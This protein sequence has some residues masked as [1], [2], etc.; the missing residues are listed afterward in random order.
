[1]SSNVR[2][3]VT[4]Q[5]ERAAA[6]VYRAVDGLNEEQA[7]RAEI[8]GWSVKDHI[9]HLAFWHELR[10][11]E[12]G[13][14]ARGAPQEFPRTEGDVIDAIN[15]TI[16]D[17]RRRL[18]FKEALADLEFTRGMVLEV[19]GEAPEARL[20]SQLYEEMT[21]LG[22]AQHELAHA[23]TIAAWREREEI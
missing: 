7:C 17:L 23:E 8:D 16:T 11:F 4:R 13:R 21:P 10:F 14:V 15:Q 3:A 9:N 5:Y 18:S 20:D 6:G 22:G 12:I 19:I 2:D 1:M